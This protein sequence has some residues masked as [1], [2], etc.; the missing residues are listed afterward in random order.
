MKQ[1]T[2]LVCLILLMCIAFVDTR[3]QFIVDSLS[4][5]LTQK[6]LPPEE[7]VTTMALL[8]RAKSITD[9]KSAMRIAEKAL[10]LSR[11][12]PDARYQ[13]LVYTHLVFLHFINEEMPLAHKA[14]DSALWY[15]DKTSDR[16]IKGF[17]WFR[18][19][20]L[21]DIQAFDHEAMATYLQALKYLEGTDA[22]I[23]QSF[24]YYNMAGT[25]AAWDDLVNEKKYALLAL[26]TARQ[27]GDADELASAYQAMA[28]WY[29]YSYKKQP[30]KRALLDSALFYNKTGIQ[31]FAEHGDHIII[32]STLGVIALNTADLYEEYFPAKYKDTAWHYLQIALNASLRTRQLSVLSACY[33]MMSDYEIAKGNYKKAEELLLTG[34]SV[35]QSYAV[36]NPRS[37]A[38]FMEGLSKLYEKMGN[39]TAALKYYKQFYSQH[40]LLYDADKLAI[41]N[42]LEAQYQSEKKEAALKTLRHTAALN[43]K[44]NYLYISLAIASIIALLFIVRFF[45]LRL[46]ATLHQQKLLENE[47]AAASLHARLKEEEAMRLQAEQQLLKERQERLQKELLAGSLQVEQKNELLQTLQKKIEENKNGGAVLKQINH[48]IDQDKRID[49]TQ[50][51]YKADFDN[52]HPEFFEKLKEKSSNTLSRLDLKHCSYI[53]LGLTN[54]EIAQRLGVAPKSILMARYRIK[55]KLGL[56]KEDD[57][58]EYIGRVK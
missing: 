18:K 50:A 15:A 10:S 35:F 2:G 24:V 19:G 48:I 12:L 13:A 1:K 7:R 26:Q 37:M 22:Y 56:G 33:A 25:Y 4:T 36:D 29:H 31:L 27:S 42:R 30:E 51:S 58:D 49:D 8:A 11:Q 52:I 54:K 45:Q 28:T 32:Q 9:I 39:P 43:R 3:A 16:R 14:S 20:W 41:T 6:N 21:Q 40:Q 17:A 23:Y 38:Q 5:R 55:L 53:S 34:I 46:K 47:N 44:L 57:L